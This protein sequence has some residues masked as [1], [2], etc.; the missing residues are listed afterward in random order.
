MRAEFP[1]IGISLY[2][3]SFFPLHITRF[4][5]LVITSVFTLARGTFQIGSSLERRFLIDLEDSKS[6]CP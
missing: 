6:S 4:S 5:P 2:I 3:P 1:R